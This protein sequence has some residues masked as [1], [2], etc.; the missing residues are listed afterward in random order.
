[1]K[2]SL[3]LSDCNEELSKIY[4]LI[5]ILLYFRGILCILKLY[6]SIPE[7]CLELC[8]IYI[9]YTAFTEENSYRC[10]LYTTFSL[11][12]ILYTWTE[13]IRKL[14]N[15]YILNTFSFQGVYSL[16]IANFSAIL[17]IITIYFVYKA[18]QILMILQLPSQGVLGSSYI[19]N[20][21]NKKHPIEAISMVNE[22]N[23]IIKETHP[24]A[25]ILPVSQQI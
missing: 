23:N 21:L 3:L 7:C 14:Q 5:T 13:F 22:D 10:T 12:E 2:N 9:V 16:I 25:A 15:P 6:Y 17:Y 24:A 1:M 11:I 20:N 19:D 8:S 4:R 18:Y